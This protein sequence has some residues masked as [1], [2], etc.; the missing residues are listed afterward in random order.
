MHD[1]RSISRRRRILLG[2]LFVS[3]GL[4]IWLA[5]TP[6]VRVGDAFRAATQPAESLFDSHPVGQIITLPLDQLV[7]I[8][9]WL[10]HPASARGTLTLRVRSLDQQRDITQIRV[11]VAGLPAD[12]PTTFNLPVDKLAPL[13]M[14]R[15]ETLELM[16]TTSGVESADPVGVGVGGNGYGYG[17]LVRDGREIPQSDL[18]FEALYQARLLD[19]I[20]PITRIAYGRPGIFGAPLFY[21][22]LIYALLILL[23]RF[24]GRLLLAAFGAERSVNI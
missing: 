13:Q 14:H 20:V 4:V 22:L 6:T 1:T 15:R 18:V 11:P 3:L 21:A 8:R 10:Q 7:G 16:L 19:R 9:L 24:V 23:A 12:G 2:L 5:V 17:L